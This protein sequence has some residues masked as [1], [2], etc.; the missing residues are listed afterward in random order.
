MIINNNIGALRSLKN[1][2]EKSKAKGTVSEKLSSGLRINRAADD[3]AGLAIS[4]KMRAQIR[5]LKQAQRNIQ[6]SIS[7]IQTAEGGLSSILNPP[8]QRLRELAVQASNDTLTDTD[9]IEIQKEV[10]QLKQSVDEIANN[11]HFN[12]IHLLNGS[13]IITNTEVI[14]EAGIEWEVIP[15]GTTDFISGV[16]SINGQYI[17]VGENGN[18]ITSPDGENWNISNIGTQSNLYEITSNGTQTIIFGDSG[19]LYTTNDGINWSSQTFPTDGVW[20]PS[21]LQLHDGLWD[22]SQY[23]IAADNGHMIS[24][25]DGINWSYSKTGAM[26]NLGIAFNGSQYITVGRSGAIYS[27]NDAT[28]WVSQVSNTTKDLKSIIWHNNRF[29][30]VGESGT[31]LTSQD[32][33]TWDDSSLGAV[34]L[35]SIISTGDKVIAVGFDT[36]GSKNMFTSDDGLNWTPIEAMGGKIILDITYNSSKNELLAVTYNGEILRSK[37]L[38]KETNKEVHHSLNFQIGSNAQQSIN[39]ELSDVRTS[40]LGIDHVDL[41]HREGAELAIDIIDK[42]IKTVSSERSYLGANQN[43]L[44]H[45]LNN[46]SNYETNLTAAESRI[47]DVD[48]AK[49]GM[50][51]VKLDILIQ[52]SQAILAQANQQPES[53]LKLLG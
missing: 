46:A 12:G 49:Q 44:E 51:S 41:S 22:G 43:R 20:N 15:S 48:I 53:V 32:G 47:R 30:A 38:T 34:R 35:D 39:L 28:T 3:S 24:S 52:T 19:S 10:E 31:V 9:R 45:A 5:G 4:E 2:N 1:L 14:R 7:L 26:Q 27:S 36:A 8:L 17:A 23:V 11:T 16:S 33:V 37:S 18:V 50:E 42:A 21:Q 40:S 25:T 6:D 29:I 13:S